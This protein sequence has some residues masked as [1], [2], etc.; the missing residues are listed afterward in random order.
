ME[1][2][3]AGALCRI[4]VTG[5]GL[6]ALAHLVARRSDPGEK[7]ES[8]AERSADRLRRAHTRFANGAT[9]LLVHPRVT[10]GLESWALCGVEPRSGLRTTSEH[11]RCGA[12]WFIDSAPAPLASIVAVGPAAVALTTAREPFSGIATLIASPHVHPSA[13]GVD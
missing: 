7:P 4:L 5:M 8:A 3:S 1:S 9:T 6:V 2:V 11:A 12:F 10:G 13:T